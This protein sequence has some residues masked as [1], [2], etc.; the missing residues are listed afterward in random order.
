MSAFVIVVTLAHTCI[1]TTKLRQYERFLLTQ[2]IRKI[3]SV[4]NQVN[5]MRHCVDAKSFTPKSISL[6][7]FVFGF[8]SKMCVCDGEKER[9]VESGRR[10]LHF[11]E[12]QFR[13]VASIRMCVCVFVRERRKVTVLPA[14]YISKI[15]ANRMKIWENKNCCFFRKCFTST[16]VSHCVFAVVCSIFLFLTTREEIKNVKSNYSIFCLE[17]HFFLNRIEYW[18]YLNALLFYTQP[19][20]RVN[21]TCTSYRN[22]EHDLCKRCVCVCVHG[23]GVICTLWRFSFQVA[24]T[25]VHKMICV[26][27][28]TY[29]NDDNEP[30]LKMLLNIFTKVVNFE[31]FV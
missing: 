15:D 22:I 4:Y 9:A 2:Q 8:H 25:S 29:A 31:S 13:C 27:S 1:H 30:Q 17:C 21:E 20:F 24:M 14:L 11:A 3:N 12:K 16:V 6:K 19:S 28:S 10:A 7:I 5:W 26:T 18:T 23:W